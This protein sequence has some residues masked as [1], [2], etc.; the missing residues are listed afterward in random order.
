MKRY[1]VLATDV[2][3]GKGQVLVVNGLYIKA[4]GWYG[5][6]DLSEFQLVQDGRFSSSVQPYLCR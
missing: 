3:D 5:G 1:L 2:P 4:N 6:H